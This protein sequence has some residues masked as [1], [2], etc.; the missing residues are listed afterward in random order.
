MTDAQLGLMLAALG[1][2]A[3]IIGAAIKWGVG[4]IVQSTDAG[5]K[6]LIENTA[7]NAVLSVKVDAMC[8][9]LDN[10]SDWMEQATPIGVIPTPRQPH[11]GNTPVQGSPTGYY[12][13]SR[14]S[15]KGER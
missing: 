9:K 14:P 5:A 15:T 13:P 3:T 11:R 12:G 7:S 4:R 2:A 6:A 10:I 8:Q 1:T